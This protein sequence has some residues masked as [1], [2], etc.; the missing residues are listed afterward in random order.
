[1][2]SSKIPATSLFFVETGYFLYE[3]NESI[4]ES[5]IYKLDVSFTTKKV[6][7]S[8]TYG[9]NNWDLLQFVVS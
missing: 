1:M 9:A 3:T 4:H 7:P 8:P 6:P 5:N 2:W